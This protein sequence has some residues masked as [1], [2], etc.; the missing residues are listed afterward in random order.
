VKRPRASR[1]CVAA[2][3]RLPPPRPFT[4]LRLRAADPS[5]RALPPLRP[6]A[7]DLSL[8]VLPPQPPL[9][10]VAP[11]RPLDPPP[12]LAADPSTPAIWKM[13]KMRNGGD[14][15]GDA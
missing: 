9:T 15:D 3:W 1:F 12:A 2:L 10:W 8:R 11:V 14:G 4:P 13:G 7:E 6:R 5:V